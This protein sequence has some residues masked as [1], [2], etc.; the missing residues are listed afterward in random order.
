[1]ANQKEFGIRDQVTK[2]WS[3]KQNTSLSVGD[4][5][6]SD[7]SPEELAEIVS[8][9]KEAQAEELSRAIAKIG[10]RVGLFAYGVTFLEDNGAPVE[11]LEKYT[12]KWQ[13]QLAQAAAKELG[14]ADYKQLLRAGT[15]T[16]EQSKVMEQLAGRAAVNRFKMYMESNYIASVSILIERTAEALHTTSQ[17][18]QEREDWDDISEALS[19]LNKYFYAIHPD[20][21]PVEKA[22]LTDG[23]REELSQMAEALVS[24]RAK[25][26]GGFYESIA[27]CFHLENVA[28]AQPSAYPLT[29]FAKSDDIFIPT[30]KLWQRQHDIAAEGKFGQTLD[31]ARRGSSPVIVSATI[32]DKEG[33]PLKIDGIRRGAQMAIGN[34]IDKNGG[35][36]PVVITPE[37]VYREWAGLEPSAVVTEQQAAEMEEAIDSLTSA[38]AKIDFTA[39]LQQHKHIKKQPDYDYESDQAGR[40]S[41]NL[42]TAEKVEAIRKNGS[43]TVA[44]RVYSYPMQYRYSHVV[45]QMA[46]VKR[47]LLTGGEKPAI[48][49]DNKAAA[50][51]NSRDVSMRHNVLTRI[52]RM[53][54]DDKGSRKILLSEVAEDLYVTLTRQTERTLIKNLEQYLGELQE[55]G[56]IKDYAPVMGGRGNRKHIGFSVVL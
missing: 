29:E 51:G 42:I 40:F 41:G 3:T 36:L 53:K 8:D 56:E 49:T 11:I 4:R 32:S 39:Q 13:E 15:R 24:Y 48:K 55:Q 9:E 26:G 16:K 28:A 18:L 37:Q 2:V 6:A 20:I 50:Q 19:F 46:Q 21:N 38:P 22:A 54:K 33:N 43:R 17:A 35:A 1:M 12:E 23:A 27:P 34:L 44:Y 45:G 14:L 10:L 52:E 30:S 7:V 5:L 25:H 47:S 31:I